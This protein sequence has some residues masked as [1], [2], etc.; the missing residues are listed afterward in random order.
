M[1][2]S[3][4]SI[5][6]KIESLLADYIRLKESLPIRRQQ[7]RFVNLHETMET[8]YQSMKETILNTYE[9][10]DSMKLKEIYPDRAADI[11]YYLKVLKECHR[12]M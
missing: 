6:C 12:M 9:T 11:D 5:S 7:Q 10:F 1:L 4:Y 2:Q 8:L 3:F